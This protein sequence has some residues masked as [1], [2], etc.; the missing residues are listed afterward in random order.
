MCTCF[1]IVLVYCFYFSL[2]RIQAHLICVWGTT[3]RPAIADSLVKINKLRESDTKKKAI[4][5][6]FSGTLTLTQEVQLRTMWVSN[7]LWE[8]RPPNPVNKNLL[9]FLSLLILLLVVL[10]L[11]LLLVIISIVVMFVFLLFFNLVGLF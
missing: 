11:L 5:A 10:L 4:I 8:Y 7:R 1:L 2:F 3:F 6:L 9:L